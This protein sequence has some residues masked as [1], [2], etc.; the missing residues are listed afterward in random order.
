ML[1]QIRIEK[2]CLFYAN[3][4]IKAIQGS[5][6]LPEICIDFSLLS[7]HVNVVETGGII[8]Y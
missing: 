3:W 7:M 5:M 4:C 2:I 1:N 6:Y 8:G